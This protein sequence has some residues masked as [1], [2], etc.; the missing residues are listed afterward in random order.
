[1]FQLPEVP[2][3][4]TNNAHMFYIILNTLEERIALIEH[5]KKDGINAVFHYLSLHNS[6]FYKTKHDGRELKNTDR[7][8]DCLLRLPL[9]FELTLQEV[10]HICKII[11]LSYR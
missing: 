10:E 9:F 2:G 3:Y 5:L 4:A 11:E 1:M 7:Y 8:T 6:E